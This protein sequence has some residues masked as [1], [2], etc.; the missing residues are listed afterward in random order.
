[1]VVEITE[2]ERI[3]D[4]GIV[5]RALDPLR[6]RG[7]RLAVDDAGAGY[8]S[9]THILRLRPD[10]IKL[11]RSL[12]TDLPTDRAQRSLVTALVLMAFDIG[13]SVTGEGIETPEQLETL[14]LLAVDAAQGYRLGRPSLDRCEWRR[15][16]TEQWGCAASASRRAS[17]SRSSSG[18]GE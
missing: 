18:H 17:V 2:H 13:A 9:M 6:A 5:N 11:D 3:V 12:V 4:D 1:M 10:I 7:M 16:A 14:G 8:A 15:W